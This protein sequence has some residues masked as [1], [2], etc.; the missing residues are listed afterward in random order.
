M[1][2]DGER[3]CSE[4]KLK[5]CGFNFEER[6]DA[7]EH[8]KAMKL[9]FNKRVWSIR[10]LK[11]AGFKGADLLKLYESLVR[12]VLDFCVP[13]YHSLLSAEQSGE[14]EKMQSRVL[15]LINDGG[16]NFEIE[17]LQERRKRLID[18]FALKIANSP[19]FSE[20]WLKIKNRNNYG[21]RKEEK[22]E[23]KRAKTRRMQRNP[24]N[25]ITMRLNELHYER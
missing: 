9:S 22:Y 10:H 23:I 1:N 13:A 6:P 14:L 17:S 2:R 15:K 25:Y 8:F 16:D 7:T 20:R 21:T 24:L 4:S 12:P 18:K 5:I 3:I 19:L 11:R